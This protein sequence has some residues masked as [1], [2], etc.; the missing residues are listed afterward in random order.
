MVTRE[1]I[2]DILAFVGILKMQDLRR[3]FVG[4]D[5]CSQR[6]QFK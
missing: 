1:P 5:E 4:P 2:N 3:V 6:E